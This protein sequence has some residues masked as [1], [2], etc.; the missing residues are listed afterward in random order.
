MNFQI[1]ILQKLTRK[2]FNIGY[3]SIL[4]VRNIKADVKIY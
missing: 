2:H 4:I 3:Y 1:K